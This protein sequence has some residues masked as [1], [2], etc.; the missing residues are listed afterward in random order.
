MGQILT[1]PGLIFYYSI[2]NLGAR[3][4]GDSRLAA[5]PGSLD[6]YPMASALCSAGM[7]IFCLV[8]FLMM[9]KYLLQPRLNSIILSIRIRQPHP[10]L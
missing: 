7:L 8:A 1:G 3:I 5:N 2:G 9:P 6:Y 4:A 10:M